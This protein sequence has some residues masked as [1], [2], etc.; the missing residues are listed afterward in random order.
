MKG[1]PGIATPTVSCQFPRSRCPVQPAMTRWQEP[2][3]HV[4]LSHWCP[5]ISRG[6]VSEE[7]ARLASAFNRCWP[8]YMGVARARSMRRCPGS[9]PA[10]HRSATCTRSKSRL[11]HFE[12]RY[13]RWISFDEVLQRGARRCVSLVWAL[14]DA[15]VPPMDYRHKPAS[16][17]SRLEA[18]S[19][20]TFEAD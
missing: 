10:F 14:R 3:V 11:R 8:G 19:G 7:V 12:H 13:L 17:G 5:G 1:D 4:F 20:S 16:T 2:L 15:R 18:D 6:V 9:V